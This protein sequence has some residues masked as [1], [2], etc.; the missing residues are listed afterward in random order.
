MFSKQNGIGVCNIGGVGYPKENVRKNQ[1]IA[2][3]TIP[4]TSPN[5]QV[6]KTFLALVCF[7]LRGFNTHCT[8]KQDDFH[9]I[10]QLFQEEN[11]E[12]SSLRTSLTLSLELISSAR[13]SFCLLLPDVFDSFWWLLQHG[14]PAFY[15]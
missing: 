4:G 6:R 1:T 8:F 9:Y 12:S 10:S 3:M 15:A 14:N 13:A 7:L 2:Y 5:P 11:E